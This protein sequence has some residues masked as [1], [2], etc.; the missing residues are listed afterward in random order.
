M[1]LLH[2]ISLAK[3]ASLTGEIS[4][5]ATGWMEWNQNIKWKLQSPEHSVVMT[6]IFKKR[7]LG[8]LGFQI[9]R[10]KMKESCKI[11]GKIS[12]ETELL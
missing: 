11:T 2:K 3:K 4:K 7:L 8:F 10:K 12:Q 9:T 1:F 5:T 6:R